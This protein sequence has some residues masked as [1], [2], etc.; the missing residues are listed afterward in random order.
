MRKFHTISHEAAAEL[1]YSQRVNGQGRIFGVAFDRL[2]KSR[3]KQRKPGDLEVLYGRFNVKKHAKTLGMGWIHQ[4]GTIRQHW[5][6]GA[7]PAGAAY[8]RWEKGLICVWVTSRKWSRERGGEVYR[9][10]CI[11]LR[12]IRW[13]KLDG[14]IYR[15]G[16][17]APVQH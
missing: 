13:L 11:P 1:L 15:V 9:Y 16:T 8:D 6:D 10:R 14:L 7:R 5:S 17:P 4:D 3:D 2:T 12:Q